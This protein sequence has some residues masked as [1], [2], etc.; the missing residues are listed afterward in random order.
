MIR[1]LVPEASLGASVWS[2]PAIDEQA[3]LVYITTANAD[4]GSSPTCFET[5]DG[6]QF[7]AVN[8]KNGV[9]YVLRRPDLSL[10]WDFQTGYRLCGAGIG[11]RVDFDPG[12]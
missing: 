9:M 4:F 12:L 10:A 2:T 1:Y 6:K 7:V 3:N 5:P 8:G 11:L